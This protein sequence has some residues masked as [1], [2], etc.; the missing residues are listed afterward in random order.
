M[1]IFQTNK[2]TFAI[3][4]IGKPA[5]FVLRG[6]RGKFTGVRGVRPILAKGRFP[7]VK[8]NA[9]LRAAFAEAIG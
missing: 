5:K 6:N 4:T 3:G 2:N 1:T 8:G 7:A 9:T